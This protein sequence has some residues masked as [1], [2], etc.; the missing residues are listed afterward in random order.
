MD[1]GR[2]LCLFPPSLTWFR[3]SSS[4]SCLSLLILL[5]P[6]VVVLLVVVML[7]VVLAAR[8]ARMRSQA[9]LGEA[10]VVEGPWWMVV[11]EV[12]VLEVLLVEDV[13]VGLVDVGRLML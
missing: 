7:V 2:D 1:G 13:L 8:L 9:P 12:E 10:V 3:S 4:S 11:V 5:A 6:L